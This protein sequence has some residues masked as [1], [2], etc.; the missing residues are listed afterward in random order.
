MFLNESVAS[1]EVEALRE[2]YIDGSEASMMRIL[3]ESS[4]EWGTL[5][6]KS[7]KMQAAAALREDTQLLTE[8]LSEV[9]G[10]I[11]D[12]FVKLWA[13][14]KKKK[15]KCR[16]STRKIIIRKWNRNSESIRPRSFSGRFDGKNKRIF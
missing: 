16:N 7:L 8:G 4:E 5:T 13:R 15:K 10:K 6:E 14:I 11:K 12:F 9:W 3:Y 1:Y 2:G